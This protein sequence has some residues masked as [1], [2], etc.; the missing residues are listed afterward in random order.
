M[1]PAFTLSPLEG[2]VNK[3]KMSFPRKRQNALQM[4]ALAKNILEKTPV[5]S[6]G[7]SG[8]MDMKLIEAI[9]KAAETGERVVVSL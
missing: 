8:L 1:K 2:Y 4:D 3:K 7:E 6:S 9:Y 5:L